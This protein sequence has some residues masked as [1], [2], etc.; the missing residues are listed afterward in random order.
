MA[1]KTQKFKYLIRTL[2]F[3]TPLFPVLAFGQDISLGAGTNTTF[4]S[5]VAYVISIINLLTPLMTIFA[6][7]IFFWGLSK[8]IIKSDN[9]AEHDKGK[10]YILWSILALFILVTFKTIV[11]LIAGDLTGTSV[12]S[13][14]LRTN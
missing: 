1:T 5:T 2:L 9:K 13:I 11:V 14:L 6:F 4:K 8:F 12:G 3:G 10:N 7:L